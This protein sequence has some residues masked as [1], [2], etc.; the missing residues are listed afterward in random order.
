MTSSA[1][2]AFANVRA[3]L[4]RQSRRDVHE[5][6]VAADTEFATDRETVPIGRFRNAV[7]DRDDAFD[8]HVL[9]IGKRE[10]L[11]LAEHDETRG[12]CV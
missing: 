6:R 11:A 2:G 12:T 10:T 3:N 8:R 4:R 7:R 9:P 1:S 5:K